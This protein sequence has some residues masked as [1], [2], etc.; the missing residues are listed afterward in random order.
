MNR[1]DMPLVVIPIKGDES[2]LFGVLRRVHELGVDTLVVNDGNGPALSARLAR[3]GQP[4]LDFGANC[5]VGA[6]T[7][8]GLRWAREKNYV[9]VVSVDSDGA[10]DQASVASVLGVAARDPIRPILCNRFPSYNRQL[11][12]DEKLAA[13]GFACRLVKDVT[14]ISLTDVTCGLRFYPKAWQSKVTANGFDFIYASLEELVIAGA[15]IIDVSVDYRGPGPWLTS[16]IELDHLLKWAVRRSPGKVQLGPIGE[17]AGDSRLELE[18][19]VK[20]AGEEWQF[21]P[22][23]SRASWLIVGPHPPAEP[24]RKM[25]LPTLERPSV[26]FIPDGGRRWSVREKQP[27]S[28]AY[29]RSFLAIADTIS[30]HRLGDSAVYCLSRANLSRTPD[31][32]GAVHSAIRTL[33]STLES[34]SLRPI[35]WGDILHWLPREMRVW[36][37]QVNLRSCREAGRLTFLATAYEP[38]WEAALFSAKGYPWKY[39][40]SAEI[41]HRAIE[42]KLSVVLRSGGANTLSNFMPSAT[43]YAVLSVRAELFNDLNLNDWLDAELVALRSVKYGL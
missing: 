13:N 6:A 34:Y 29:T 21:I 11:V 5:G 10:H 15:K 1:L 24:E 43:S 18:H 12:P 3:S 22:V 35:L 4:Y 41:L 25:Y 39:G 37:R 38:S 9:G 32:L 8:A 33:V 2:A 14:G 16:A 36:A 30:S 20:M 23:P 40:Y 31:E 28:D 7:R 42:L 17:L 19:I 27:L 26:G